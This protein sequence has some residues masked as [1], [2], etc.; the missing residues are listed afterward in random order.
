M[1]LK[2]ILLRFSLLILLFGCQRDPLAIDSSNTKVSIAFYNLDKMMMEA[3][4]LELL[5]LHKKMKHDISEV[6]DYQVGYC[7][8]IGDVS[9]TTF[10]SSF[11][12]YK[13]DTFIQKLEKEIAVKF[14]DT[15]K[16]ENEIIEGFRNIQTHLPD[17]KMPKHV[18]F[19]NSLFV[20]NAFSTEKDLA[21]GLER[22]L[23]PTSPSIQRLPS[24]PFYSWMK[25]GMDVKYLERD[26]I[27]SWVMTHVLAEEEGNLAQQMIRWGKILYLT[28][29]AF[30][31][32]DKS[33][34]MRYSDKDLSWA[35]ENEASFWKYLIDQEMLFKIDEQITQNMLGDG[36]FTPGLPD[37]KAPDRLGQYLGWRM[38]K[39]F[40]ET[41][42]TSFEELVKMSYND[43][44]QS[45]EIE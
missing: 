32:L 21:I 22:Y 30:P 3:D 19:M 26:A 6:F 13:R 15:K 14:P 42:E 20:S 39:N 27:A 4:S 2:S 9:D 34:I 24:E 41:T 43:I 44:L 17:A 36:P 7:I 28:E 8:Q 40:M 1:T 5:A 31:D 33:I 11:L 12:E 38:V 45:Y 25:E 29:A 35:T 37:E 18:V 10:A 16:H 23:G